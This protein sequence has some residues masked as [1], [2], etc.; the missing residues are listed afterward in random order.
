MF[1]RIRSVQRA[2]MLLFSAVAIAAAH[3][4][5]AAADD[6]IA[7]VP[8][9][10]LGIASESGDFALRGK[11]LFAFDAGTFSGGVLS[12]DDDRD[13]R[14]V[15]VNITGRAFRDFKFQFAYDFIDENNPPFRAYKN[16]VLTYDG[17]K[18]FSVTIGNQKVPF[19][20]QHLNGLPQLVF[21]E[22]ALPFALAPRRRVGLSLAFAGE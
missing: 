19:S 18:P 10:G 6:S 7:Y 13:V 21:N 2:V 20:Q 9:R 16:V 1:L 17:L 12:I 11:G 14:D 3:L 4:P 15:I 22:R 8:G 5:K